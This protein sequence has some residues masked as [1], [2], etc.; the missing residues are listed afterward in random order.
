MMT[1]QTDWQSAI[2]ILAAGLIVGGM[3]IYFFGRKRP[4][5]RDLAAKRDALVKQLRALSDDQVEE[6]TRLELE[7]AEVLREIDH[8]KKLDTRRA[9][10]A[11]RWLGFAVGA[12]S[13]LAVGALGYFV[14]RSA[15][16]RN[17]QESAMP[18][19][20]QPVDATL[21]TLEASVQKDP[22]NLDQRIELARAYVERNNL[23]GVFEQ[24]QYVLAKS[25]DDSRALTYQAIVRM[26]MGD[27]GAATGMLQK[28]LKNDPNFL[29]AYVITAWVQTQAGN[30]A[31]AEKAMKEGLRR[32][33]EDKQRLDHVFAQMKGRPNM[34]SA[35]P[36]SEPAARSQAI[37]ITLEIDAKAK[38]KPGVIFVIARPAGA[39][40][41]HPLAV[42]RIDP[43]SL[44]TTFDLGDADSMMGEPLPA[45]VR[46][47]A[48]LD[49]DGD[50]ITRTAGDP[51][52]MQDGVAAGS[53]ITL[54]LK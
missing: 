37:R 24:T 42:K 45:K 28:A 3:I 22:D 20:P 15:S 25:P 32:H 38:G 47:E 21:Q 26:S 29:D 31:E 54:A 14:S 51:Y 41:G 5:R 49:S 2:A 46:V 8:E 39:A 44:P 40:S 4:G 6:R 23:M 13:M 9:R 48:R 1:P 17:P 52:A 50:V 34:T 7:T 43:H 27:T 53:A 35:A 10:P 16:T 36:E 30:T 18:A 12:A 33:P 11:F 19:V